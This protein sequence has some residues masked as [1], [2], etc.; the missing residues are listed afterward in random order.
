MVF[1]LSF[2]G[3]GGSSLLRSF[4]LLVCSTRP[5][6][7]RAIWFQNFSRDSTFADHI[8]VAIQFVG[9]VFTYNVTACSKHLHM[10]VQMFSFLPQLLQYFA[11]EPLT[12]PQFPHLIPLGATKPHVS[13][14]SSGTGDGA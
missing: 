1:I 12:T 14:S 7:A 3:F 4:S 13:S 5:S 8:M 9:L 6:R 11:F 10:H 2:L